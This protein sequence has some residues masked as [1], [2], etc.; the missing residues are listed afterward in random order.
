MSMCTLKFA[1][2]KQKALGKRAFVL[3]LMTDKARSIL[4]IFTRLVFIDVLGLQLLNDGF[5]E[6]SDT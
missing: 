5:E 2:Q 4:P 1:L 3:M 6:L